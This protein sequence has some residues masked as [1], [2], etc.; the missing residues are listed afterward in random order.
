MRPSSRTENVA[1]TESLSLGPSVPNDVLDI[2]S[3]LKRKENEPETSGE[4]KEKRLKD[5]ANNLNKSIKDVSNRFSTVV[6][7]QGK[8]DKLLN[9]STKR[10]DMRLKEREMEKEAMKALT[11][12]GSLANEITNNS[13]I[14]TEKI[15]RPSS[16]F[17]KG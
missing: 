3:P 8:K 1:R 17:D 15:R 16:N 4:R 14:A 10:E 12:K 9:H 2:F 6:N 13:C 5:S 11:Q 7:A